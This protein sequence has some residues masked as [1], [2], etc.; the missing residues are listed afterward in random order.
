MKESK[1][2]LSHS[3]NLCQ[4]VRFGTTVCWEGGHWNFNNW[5]N[6]EPALVEDKSDF[7]R[8]IAFSGYYLFI[9]L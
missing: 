3:V 1:V 7:L 5:F 8:Q 6:K 9:P 4:S 2:Y